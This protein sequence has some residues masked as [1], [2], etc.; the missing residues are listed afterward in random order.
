MGT[1][2]SAQEEHR[3]LHADGEHEGPRQTELH[4]P[5]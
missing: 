4:E 3:Y 5:K 2:G 1:D